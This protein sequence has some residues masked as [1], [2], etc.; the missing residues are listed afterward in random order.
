MDWRIALAAAIV[1][2]LLGSI[3]GARLVVRRV[4]PD[5][6]SFHIAREYM[7][8]LRPSDLDQPETLARLASVTNLTPDQFRAQFAPAVAHWKK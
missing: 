3:S 4:N 2:Y 5:S 1:G 6:S 7:V 8:R